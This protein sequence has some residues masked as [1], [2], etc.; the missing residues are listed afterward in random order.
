MVLRFLRMFWFL[1]AFHI[2]DAHVEDTQFSAFF[3]LGSWWVDIDVTTTDV[4][5]ESS[6]LVS[7]GLVHS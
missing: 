6:A 1:D 2:N 4:D 7:I 5:L 3:C